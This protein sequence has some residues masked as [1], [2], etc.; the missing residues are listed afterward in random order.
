MKA[1]PYLFDFKVSEKR[2]ETF[3][4]RKEENK[5]EEYILNWE[6]QKLILKKKNRHSAVLF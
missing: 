1:V 3:N 6:R 2:N 4:N 5:N